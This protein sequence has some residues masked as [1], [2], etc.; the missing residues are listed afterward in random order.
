MADTPAAP[1]TDAHPAAQ[2]CLVQNYG[3]QDIRFVRGEGCWL[4]DDQGRRYLDAFAGVAV[5]ALGHAH[6]ALVETIRRQVGVLVHTSNHYHIV[7][8]ERLAA[9]IVAGAFPGR[10]LFC[11]SGTEANEA[12]YK[13][14]RLWGNQVH[15]GRKTRMLAFHNG[16]HGRTL[17][18]LSI[19]AN[20]A[21]REPFA[22]LPAAEF[23]PFGDLAAVRAA[24]ADDVAAI[25]VEPIQGEGGVNVA[26]SGFLTGLRELCDRHAA[27]LVIDEIQTGVA[28]TGRMY[29]HQHDGVV[30]DIMTLAKGL[31][32]GVPIGAVLYREHC[33]ALLKP[34]MHGTTFGGNHLA[35]AAGLTVLEQVGKPGFLARVAT[36]GERLA[37]GL[38]RIFPGK[39]V[40]GR[41]LLLGVQLDQAP[42]ALVTA[43]RAEGLIVGPSGNNTLRIAPPLIISDAEVDDLVARLER[44]RGR[45]G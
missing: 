39:Q 1:Q 22:P 3:R 12:A 23:L 35:C 2:S 24:C 14:V 37:A 33:A 17:G 44:A 11:N 13:V 7:E 26:P 6:P 18:A 21:Y 45:L 30:P 38:R 9:A 15:A 34:G 28:R 43:A 19:T 31:G 20:P 29:A 27:L 36:A 8:Q 32:G 42:A 10:M 5:C 41:G 25:F 4:T 16:F 40:R